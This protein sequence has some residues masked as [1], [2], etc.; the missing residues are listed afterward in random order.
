MFEGY[1]ALQCFIVGLIFLGYSILLTYGAV[2]LRRQHLRL[3]R[4]AR[5]GASRR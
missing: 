2:L 3:K 1:T 4:I 5:R